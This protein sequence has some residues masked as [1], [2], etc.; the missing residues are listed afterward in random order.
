MRQFTYTELIKLIKAL[1]L[2]NNPINKDLISFYNRLKDKTE[3]EILKKIL[4]E[5]ET[6]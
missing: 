4:A 5:L 6:I 3:K 1:E 2:E